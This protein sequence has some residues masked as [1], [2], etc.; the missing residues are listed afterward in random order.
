MPATTRRITLTPAGAQQSLNMG[1]RTLGPDD[2]PLINEYAAAMRNGAWLP[3]GAMS[4][5]RD[6][7]MRN[8]HLRCAAVCRA[9]VSIEVVVVTDEVWAR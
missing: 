3:G 9:N 4:T 7:R 8:G 1:S 2:E 5:Y 6:G